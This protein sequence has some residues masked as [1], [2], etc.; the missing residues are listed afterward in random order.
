MRLDRTDRQSTYFR[1]HLGVGCS[2]QNT[3]PK[4][5]PKDET[6]SWREGAAHSTSDASQMT[7]SS[8]P[9]RRTG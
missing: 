1:S 5:R 4:S 2:G 3:N 6:E 8:S 9:R 7:F